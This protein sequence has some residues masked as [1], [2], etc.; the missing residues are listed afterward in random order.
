MHDTAELV[1]AISQWPSLSLFSTS[2]LC[3]QTAQQQSFW[4]TTGNVSC[5]GGRKMVCSALE[6]S[7]YHALTSLL[8][9]CHAVC[10]PA[11]ATSVV[12]A[13]EAAI[14][15]W[16]PATGRQMQRCAQLSRQLRRDRTAAAAAETDKLLGT[17]RHGWLL[18]RSR[19]EKVVCHPC[20]PACCG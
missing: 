14:T 9:R 3:P 13:S 8:A 16:T 12:L 6:F 5:Y 20:R 7:A 2:T 19:L 15:D 4:Q 10:R 17:T 18:M 1:V 11:A